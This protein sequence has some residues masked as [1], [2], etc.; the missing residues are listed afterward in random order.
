MDGDDPAHPQQLRRTGGGLGAHGVVV[1][2]GEQGQVRAPQLPDQGHVPEE[3]G[4]PGVVDTVTVFQLQHVPRR[5]PTGEKLVPS[6][7]LELCRAE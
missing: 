7:T 1:P 2:D 3:G 6:A 4:V 5:E